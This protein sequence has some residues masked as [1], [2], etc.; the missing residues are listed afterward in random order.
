M[1]YSTLR[2]TSSLAAL[3]LLAACGA[4]LPP[5]PPAAVVPLTHSVEQ[6]N[7][8]LEEAHRD[9]DAIEARYDAEEVLCGQR[10]FVT[11]CIEAAREKRRAALVTVRAVEIEA[12]YFKRKHAA[13]ERDRAL[14]EAQRQDEIAAARRAAEPPAAPMEEKPAH[15]PKPGKTP[16]QSETAHEAKLKS[17]AAREAA[18]ADKRAANAVAFEEKE[19]DAERRKQRVEEKKAKRAAK[20]GAAQE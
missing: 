10:F 20:E 15:V 7:S 12:E 4:T 18:R 1:A 5:E 11:R 13:D 2:S 8:K 3:A 14:A 6:A 9:R 19:K 16:Q 17:I